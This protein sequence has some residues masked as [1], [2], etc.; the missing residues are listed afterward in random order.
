MYLDDL[1]N[2]FGLFYHINDLTHTIEVYAKCPLSNEVKD[3][4]KEMVW[5]R[6]GHAYN[7]EFKEVPNV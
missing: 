5:Q 3:G 2:I 1:T 6:Y 4:I 7:V